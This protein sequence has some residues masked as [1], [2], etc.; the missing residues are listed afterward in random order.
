MLK[1]YSL[2]FL[3]MISFLQLV[4]NEEVIGTLIET[5][6]R[7]MAALEMYESLASTTLNPDTTE[8]IT[9]SLANTTIDST[10]HSNNPYLSSDSSPEAGM[11]RDY[12]THVHPDLEDLS[13]GSIGD[14]SRL[15]AP[16][17][18]STMSDDEQ[19]GVD[20]RG[21]LS[22]FS[23]YESS[24]EE[25]HRNNPGPSKRGYVTVSDDE[26]GPVGA[27]SKGKNRKMADPFADP[28]ADT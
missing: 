9:S 27:A 26:D 24:D 25:T 4:E 28:F 5:N 11:N 14:S 20:Q 15:P 23:D 10:K 2:D 18:P 21:S 7:L 3:V 16:L 6:D 22:D 1:G 8:A 19:E 17:R 12:P 13:F